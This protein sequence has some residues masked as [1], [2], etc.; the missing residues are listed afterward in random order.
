MRGKVEDVMSVRP[1]A[2]DPNVSVADAARAMDAEDVGSLP[3][4]V[5][6]G[7]LI[8]IVTDRDIAV[9]VVAQGLD[10]EGTTVGQ[11]ASKDVVA[12]RADQDLDEALSVMA[13]AQ[14]RRLPVVGDDD[15][16]VGVIAQADLA[17]QGKDKETGELVE[18][19]SKPPTG[20]RL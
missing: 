10:P 2:V 19:I 11:V 18:E 16:L 13:E 4:V 14:V 17:L 15:E 9:R 7:R 20:P 3:V 1:R 12:V 6:G 5:E 8:G